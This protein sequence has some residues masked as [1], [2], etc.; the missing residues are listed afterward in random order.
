MCIWSVNRLLH[1]L[2]ILL[3]CSTIIKRVEE[4]GSRSAYQEI[5]RDL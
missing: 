2:Q 1:L 3:K 4:A 5:F